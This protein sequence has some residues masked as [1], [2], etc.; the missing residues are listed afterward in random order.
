MLNLC[1]LPNLL[2]LPVLLNLLDLLDWLDLPVLPDL[3]DL[4]VLDLPVPSYSARVPM[5]VL[6]DLWMNEQ[7]VDLW[8]ICG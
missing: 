4:P 1:D 3:L 8:M 5:S 7:M 2:N 6:N